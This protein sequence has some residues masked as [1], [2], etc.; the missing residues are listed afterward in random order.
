MAGE[1][2]LPTSPTLLG[3]LSRLPVDQAAWG[4]FAERYGRIIFGWCRHWQLQEADAEEVTQEV[5]VKL[6]RKMA[7]FH[8]DPARSFRAWLK[9]VAHH[10][11]RDFLD[12]RRLPAA[13]SGDSQVLQA[14]QTIEARDD[15][16]N[17]LDQEFAH[18]LL[19]EATA[20][21]RLRIQPHT[22]EAFR[23]QALEG[24]SGTDTAQRLGMKVA[25]AYVARSKV[26][27]MLQDEVR[28]LQG[29]DGATD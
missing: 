28:R 3:R 6:A 17:H 16:V 24:L 21:V 26:Q 18:E 19:D 27:K 12:G 20:R 15:L 23:L 25:T 22:W 1:V 8:Y 11:W 4:E 14:L 13:G 2:S 7:S 29:E 9:T 5:L 10:V